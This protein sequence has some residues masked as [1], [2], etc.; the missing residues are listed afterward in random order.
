MSSCVRRH[1]FLIQTTLADTLVISG[2]FEVLGE[3]HVPITAAA[4]DLLTSQNSNAALAKIQLK[5]DSPIIR[6]GS[7]TSSPSIFALCP[8]WRPASVP[9]RQPPLRARLRHRH[10]HSRLRRMAQRVRRCQD[11][12]CAARPADR[13]PAKKHAVDGKDASHSA[14]LRVVSQTTTWRARWNREEMATAEA[15]I[16]RVHAAFCVT[17]G[18][19]RGK[20]AH[21]SVSSPRVWKPRGRIR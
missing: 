12:D 4:N 7:L 2:R 19:T 6:L 8:V 9:S 13:P 20:Q 1:G 5:S 3:V 15:L 10:D 18:V 16:E 11:D 21:A 14:A 17:L